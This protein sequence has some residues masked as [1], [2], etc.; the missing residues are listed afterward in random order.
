MKHLLIPYYIFK[1][2]VVTSKTLLQ[3]GKTPNTFCAKVAKSSKS[4]VQRSCAEVAKVAKVQ[5]SCAEV[6]KVAKV[7]RSCA[8]VAKV[9]KVQRSCAEVAKV[10]IEPETEQIEPETEQIEPETKVQRSCAEVAKG[11]KSYKV[12]RSY[13]KNRKRRTKSR[14]SHTSKAA[15]RQSEQP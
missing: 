13:A 11:A 2:N 14:K 8:E 5:R 9:A 15:A 1:W 3:Q 10:A 7:Q 6:A 12:A 4:C